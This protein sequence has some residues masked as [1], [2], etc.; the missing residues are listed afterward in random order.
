MQCW[1]IPLLRPFDKMK[2]P[3]YLHFIKMEKWTFKVDKNIR[4]YFRKMKRSRIGHLK[5][6][7]TLF[8]KIFFLNKNETH[9][10]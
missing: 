6:K 10:R 4:A 2:P 8:E 5:V 7:T 1:R 9:K 3:V